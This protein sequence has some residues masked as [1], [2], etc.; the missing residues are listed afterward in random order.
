M[1][2]RTFMGGGLC[3]KV[4]TSE[5]MVFTGIKPPCMIQRTTSYIEPKLSVFIWFVTLHTVNLLNCYFA[6]NCI[7]REGLATLLFL[8]IAGTYF[9]VY[10]PIVI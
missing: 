4:F 3:H 10:A 1:K 2:Y 6:E 7:G 9:S 5:V 8:L